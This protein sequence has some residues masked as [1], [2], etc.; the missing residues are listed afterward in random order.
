MDIN[1]ASKLISDMI[2]ENRDCTVKDYIELRAEIAGITKYSDTP[3]VR[4][5]NDKKQS[6][7]LE[8]I[9]ITL[10]RT[11]VLIASYDSQVKAVIVE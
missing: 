5:V 6:D 9:Q 1:Q 4:K 3:I 11:P 2:K 7:I 10:D 8:N